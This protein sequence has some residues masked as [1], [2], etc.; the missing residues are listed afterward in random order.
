MGKDCNLS[1]DMKWLSEV[2]YDTRQLMIKSFVTNFKSAMTNFKYGNNKGFSFNYKSKRN[3]N[4]IFFV[5]HRAIKP[6]L[7]IFNNRLKNEKLK[8]RSKKPE[9]VEEKYKKYK[10]Y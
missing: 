4:Q 2:P 9:M 7:R 10:R 6:D 3:P 5:D 8:M 1:K